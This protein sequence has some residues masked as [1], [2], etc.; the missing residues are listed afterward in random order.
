MRGNT[1]R[2][3]GGDRIAV[4]AGDETRHD[5][6]CFADEVVVDF[7]S[8]ASAVD[9]VRS[10]FLGSERGE[11]HHATIQLSPEE[12]RDGATR[13]L[14]VPVRCT[15][16]ECGGRGESWTERCARCAG[17]GIELFRHQLQVTL[18]PGVSDGA[19]FHFTVTPRHNPSTRIE[20]RVLIS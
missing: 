12:A 19:C 14:D 15:C 13:P 5:V 8:V 10:A 6:N 20:L 17:S 11:A 9:R 1:F 18:P 7:P 2:P 16:V 3:F 4:L